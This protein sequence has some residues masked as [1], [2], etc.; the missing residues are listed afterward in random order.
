MAR[1]PKDVDDHLPRAAANLLLVR[2]ALPFCSAS[3]LEANEREGAAECLPPLARLFLV[4]GTINFT[5]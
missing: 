5:G 1:P 4:I 2:A 3:A